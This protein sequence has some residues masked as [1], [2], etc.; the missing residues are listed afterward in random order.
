MKKIAERSDYTRRFQ[1]NH[2]LLL[3]KWM[4]ALVSTKSIYSKNLA[5][6]QIENISYPKKEQDA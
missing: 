5:T 4:H 6:Y 2:I 1:S 3:E